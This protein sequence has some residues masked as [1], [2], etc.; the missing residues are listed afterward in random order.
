MKKEEKAKILLQ[1]FPELTQ[2]E[3]DGCLKKM[4]HFMMFRHDHQSCKC[5]NCGET[6]TLTDNPEYLLNLEHKK[7]SV[8]PACHQPVTAMCDCYCYSV[9]GERNAS[10]F[11]IFRKG[12]NQICYAFCIRI[13]LRMEKSPNLPAREHYRITETQRY[14]FDGKFCYRYWKHSSGWCYTKN[15]TEPT[16]DQSGMNYHRDLNYQVLDFSPLKDTCLQYAQL[17]CPDLTNYQMFRYIQFYCKHPNVEYLIKIGCAK[18]IS[19]WFGYYQSFVPDWIDWQQNDVRKML[20]LNAYELREIRRRNIA[21]DVYHTAKENTPFL[22]ETERLE[23]IPVIQGCYGYLSVFSD[24]SKKRKVLKYLRKQNQRYSVEN[25]HV[26]LS[27]YRDYLSECRELHYDLKSREIRFPRCLADAHRRTSS[28]L[29]A[30]RAEQERQEQAKRLK[31]AQ[32]LFAQHLKERQ[33]LAFQSGNLLIRIPESVEEIVKEGARQ[34]HCVAGYAR[35]HAEGKLHI[36]FIRQKDNPDKPFYTMEVSTNGRIVQV[37]G[38]RN[39]DP[40]PEVIEFVEKYKI[41]LQAVFGK[42]KLM[43]SAA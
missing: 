27:D 39:R 15:Y 14:A 1:D 30:I 12:E 21:V 35:R 8:C 11:V 10:N 17:D 5:G 4:K 2:Q 20:G 13:R 37:R 9:E 16:W 33:K 28:A 3:I 6:I 36:L 38:E 43:E 18:M 23:M 41:Y 26:L 19:E 40:T 34:H 32:K 42:R 22:S 31:Q 24:D 7:D 29:Q 25:Q